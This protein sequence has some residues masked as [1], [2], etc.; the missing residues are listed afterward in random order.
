MY[1]AWFMPAVCKGKERAVPKVVG[2][3]VAAS[4][5]QPLVSTTDLTATSASTPSLPLFLDLPSLHDDGWQPHHVD[6]V[7]LG[8]PMLWD[9]LEMWAM[10]IEQLPDKHQCGIVVMPDSRVSL[11]GIHGMQLIKRRNPQPEALK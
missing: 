9:V 1:P 8:M 2:H 4:S 10:W 6:E 5:G 11:C 3:Q 7:H